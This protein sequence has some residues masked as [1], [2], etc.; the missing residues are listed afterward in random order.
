LI[1]LLP[2]SQTVSY[3]VKII[4]G[5]GC[6]DATS[7]SVNITIRGLPGSQTTQIEGPSNLC[8]GAEKVYFRLGPIFRD[9]VYWQSQ[10]G[11]L[12]S[13]GTDRVFI[14]Y[15]SGISAG[16]DTVSAILF[17]PQIGCE[18]VVKMP[19]NI[20]PNPAPAAGLISLKSGSNT[21][22]YSDSTSGYKFSWGYI[23]RSSGEE[24]VLTN[25]AS[26]PSFDFVGGVDTTVNI[27]FVLVDNTVCE[28]R[29]V[30]ES[31]SMPFDL[32]ENAKANPFTIYPNPT[33]GLLK[34]EGPMSEVLD[35]HLLN[36]SGQ[37]VHLTFNPQSRELNVPE[38]ISSGLYIILIQ[39]NSGFFQQKIQ[40]LK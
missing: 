30:Y 20:S 25:S 21:L 9:S 23:E 12:A 13:N 17:D 18:R 2:I 6:G 11:V 7:N 8:K 31:S 35:I 28:T 26:K 37:L 24:Y 34:I 36:T 14:D 38:H 40:I 3:R 5:G 16:Y 27:Y 15:G 32:I 33:Q 22:V 39:T 29:V 19:V 10:K 4:D 1:D